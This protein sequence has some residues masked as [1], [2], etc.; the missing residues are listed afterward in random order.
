M[1]EEIPNFYV[2]NKSKKIVCHPMINKNK[3][4]GK[5]FKIKAYAQD[6][7]WHKRQYTVETSRMITDNKGIG[8][9]YFDANDSAILSMDID[10]EKKCIK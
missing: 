1:T 8:H 3:E 2:G 5:P 7:T 6:F 4:A 10:H 9:I